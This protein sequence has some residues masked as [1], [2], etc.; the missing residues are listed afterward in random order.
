MSASLHEGMLYS[1]VL[2]QYRQ[3]NI[4]NTVVSETSESKL[5]G[6]RTEVPSVGGSN[7]WAGGLLELLVTFCVSIEELSTEQH[8]MYENVFII[9][10]ILSPHNA[11]Q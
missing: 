5:L 10:A 9:C 7:D 2:K 1:R 8:Y 6:A 4:T 3:M 11:F